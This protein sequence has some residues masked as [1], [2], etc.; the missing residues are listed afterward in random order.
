MV[1]PRD[2]RLTN[3]M[4][5]ENFNSR[6]QDLQKQ[7]LEAFWE[8]QMLEIY[9][10]P[11]D[12]KQ[13]H[14]LPIARIKRIMKANEEVKMT[15][16]DAPIVFAKAC[17]FFIQELTLRSWLHTEESRRRTL[18]R[19][20][21]ANA[22]SHGDVLDFLVDVVSLEDDG[23]IV[24]NNGGVTECHPPNG[25]QFVMMNPNLSTIKTTVCEDQVKKNCRLL[26][27]S[28]NSSSRY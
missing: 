10:L 28:Y 6:I 1:V 11:V 14:Q 24:I 12:F 15:S 27:Q 16:A 3:E 5:E 26:I 4:E 9:Q 25:V 2:Q 20:D 8:Q 23:E 13:N 18:Q 21:I 7:N 22:I 19:D 17:E